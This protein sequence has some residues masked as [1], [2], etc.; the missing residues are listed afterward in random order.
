MGHQ[1]TNSHLK[2]V[3][4][5][6]ERHATKWPSPQ[7]KWHMTD[8]TE[9]MSFMM[10]CKEI[11]AG[12]GRSDVANISLAEMLVINLANIKIADI[13]TRHQSKGAHGIASLYIFQTETVIWR[14]IYQIEPKPKRVRQLATPHQSIRQLQKHAWQTHMTD[15]TLRKVV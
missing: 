14:K 10:G 2:P 3:R 13:T 4:S 8:R 15:A 1:H 12:N 6:G 9:H 5:N 11:G 7:M